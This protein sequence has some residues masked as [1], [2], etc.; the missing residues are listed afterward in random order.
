M[1]RQRRSA[2]WRR[3]GAFIGVSAALH[4]L[5]LAALAVSVPAHPIPVPT[6]HA[7]TGARAPMRVL[8]VSAASRPT[9]FV[10]PRAAHTPASIAPKKRRALEPTPSAAGSSAWTEAPGG[11]PPPARLP[12]PD[13][14]VNATATA[15][16]GIAVGGMSFGTFGTAGST[17]WRAVQSS[18]PNAQAVSDAASRPEPAAWQ[19]SQVRQ[20]PPAPQVQMQQIW[21]AMQ[22]QVDRWAPPPDA[23]ALPC[24]LARGDGAA[25]DCDGITDAPGLAALMDTARTFYS[26]T[27]GGRDVVLAYATHGYR[28]ELGR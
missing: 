21:A 5:A 6:R 12:V 24:V 9:E 28:I 14:A 10:A 2:V 19:V 3:R 11:S 1:T 22:A 13:D 17:R 23:A 27:P 26:L 16:Q 15:V 25:P 7:I 20:I 18:A 8:L 4:L